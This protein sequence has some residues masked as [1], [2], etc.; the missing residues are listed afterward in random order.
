M[1]QLSARVALEANGAQLHLFYSLKVQG[2]GFRA[3]VVITYTIDYTRI[4]AQQSVHYTSTNEIHCLGPMRIC[5]DNM[6][7]AHVL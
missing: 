3:R 5:T 6:Q 1:E 7:I 2:V 4:R